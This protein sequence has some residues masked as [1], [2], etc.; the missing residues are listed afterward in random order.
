V[1]DPAVVLWFTAIV[2]L[3]LRYI[4]KNP[5]A[6]ADMDPMFAVQLFAEHH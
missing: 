1:F 6:L 5:A 3:G 2:V 4:L